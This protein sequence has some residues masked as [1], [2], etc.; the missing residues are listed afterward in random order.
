MK[1][2]DLINDKL[3]V[4]EIIDNTI[5]PVEFLNEY[6]LDDNTKREIYLLQ[7]SRERIGIDKN[8]KVSYVCSSVLDE[9]AVSDLKM[10]HI[11]GHITMEDFYELKERY[12]Y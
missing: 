4:Q 2:Y 5:I 10:A 9:M 12:C 8:D 11:Y 7:I 3:N 6:D 1:K